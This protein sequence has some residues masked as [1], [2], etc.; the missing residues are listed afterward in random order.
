ME[1]K[2]NP[3]CSST[4]VNIVVNAF[5]AHTA[6]MLNS[7]TIHAMRKTSSLP[8]P[9]KT[10]LLSLAVS[11]LAVG[12]VAQP[13]WIAVMVIRSKQNASVSHA[14][15]VIVYALSHASLFGIMALSVDRFLAIHL[16]L[17]YQ[18]LVTHKR[19]IA[20]VILTWML[21]T[22][23]SSIWFGIKFEIFL[24]VFFIIWSLCFI[25]TTFVYFRL[26]FAVRRH[27]NQIQALQVQQAAQNGEME[28]AVR[29]RKS[30]VSTFFVY[31]VF[32]VCYFPM[33]S[34]IIVKI[35]GHADSVT[36]YRLF[37][38]SHIPM[39]LN[40]SLNPVI[41]CWRMRHIRHT[42]MDI[43]RNIYQKLLNKME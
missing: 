15:S 14:M 8:R 24:L 5:S 33:Y 30:A 34:S 26:Y 6:I 19:V 42:I 35:F 18:E 3:L 21:S 7:L 12:L 2:E 43:L 41:Y 4:I 11:D 16:H 32:L 10:L 36:S 37:L 39:F 38:Y 29:L 23:L 9:Q 20:I 17:R 40:S 28:N 1:G 25:C 22:F 31:L 13:L 27:T